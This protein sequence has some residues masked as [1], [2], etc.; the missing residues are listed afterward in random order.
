MGLSFQRRQKREETC[1]QE[2]ATLDAVMWLKH[3]FPV[4]PQQGSLILLPFCHN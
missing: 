3:I 4:Q 1:M 2:H